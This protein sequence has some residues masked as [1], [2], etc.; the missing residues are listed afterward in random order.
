[1]NL[2]QQGL[3]G[4]D[5]PIADPSLLGPAFAGQGKA[6]ITVRNLLL[7]NSGMANEC[8]RFHS[9]LLE[10]FMNSNIA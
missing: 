10:T 2:Y 5:T 7:H 1:M 9:L 6:T 8:C 3:L 4:L